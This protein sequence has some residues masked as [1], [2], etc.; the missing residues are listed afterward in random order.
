MTIDQRLSTAL[1]DRYRIE[2]EL[3]QGGMATVYL[4][5]DLKHHRKVAIKILRPELAAVVGA[6]RFVREIETTAALQHPHILGLIDSGEVNGT[7]YYVMP[8]VEGESL[9]DRITREKQLPLDDALRMA[10]E[11]ADALS[12]AHNKGVIH[13]DIKPENILLTSGHAVVADFGIARAISA[14]GGERLTETGLAVG[15]PAYMSPEQAAGDRDLDGRSDL[16]ALACV[17]YEMLAGEPPFR[18]PTVQDV[19]RQHLTIE[20]RSVTQ[21]RPAVPA[22]VAEAL[23]RALAKT[24][25]DRFNPVGQFSEALGRGTPAAREGTTRAIPTPRSRAPAI[26][27]VVAI[28]ALGGIGLWYWRHRGV[29]PLEVQ[30]RTQVTIDPGIEI[31]PALSP[32]G[33]FVAYS[34]AKGAIMVRQV[35]GGVPIAVVRDGGG[36][37]RWPAWTPDGQRLVYISPRGFEIVPALGGS[38]RLVRPASG[39]PRGVAVSPDGKDFVFASHDSVFVQPLDREEPRLVT[40]GW[41]VH[42]LAWSRDG[43]WIAFVSGNPQYIKTSDLGNFAPSSIWLAPAAGGPPVRVTDQVFLNVSPAWAPD[44]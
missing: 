5:E 16:Y 32:D 11:V 22:E 21:L 8:F 31:D 23:N 15:T 40:I 7:A 18:G 26:A 19:V 42:S 44:G 41:E 4:A 37:G 20:P 30:R 9:R 27:G 28:L 17:L 1:A 29:P 39:L 6:D 38:S 3:G 10:R 13:R 24:P 2:R 12:Y 43:R 14:A 33:K 34:G 36:T 25:A 35:G